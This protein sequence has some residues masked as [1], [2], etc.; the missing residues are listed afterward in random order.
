LI[1]KSGAGVREGAENVAVQA[2][3]YIASDAERLAPFL[4]ASGIDASAIRAAAVA[5]GFL[6]GVLDYVAG[7]ERLLLEVAREIGRSP[8]RV[9]QARAILGGRA[10]EA[11]T[12]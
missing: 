5:P 6:A 7:N 2:F 1:A 8:E 10:W 4:A 12:P 9:M 11:D 3:A